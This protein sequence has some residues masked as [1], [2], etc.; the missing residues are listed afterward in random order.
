MEKLVADQHDKGEK[1]QLEVAEGAEDIIVI[2]S[3]S[4]KMLHTY[5]HIF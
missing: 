1:T 2:D 5:I 4:N 3:R